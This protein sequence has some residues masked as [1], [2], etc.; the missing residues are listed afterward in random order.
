[1]IRRFF[2]ALL[3]ALMLTSGAY[4]AS[5]TGLV[6]LQ[7][8][9]E[10]DSAADQA[11]KLKI[12]DAC[13]DCAR[14]CVSGAPDA[15]AAYMRLQQHIGDFQ[16]ACEARARELGYA[17]TITAEAGVFAFPDRVYGRARVPAGDYPALRITI[18]AGEGRNWWCVLYP[19]LCSLDESARGI[20]DVIAWLRRRL[21]GD[22]DA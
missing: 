3:A 11:L 1:M 14:V 12:R 8:V 20:G 18:G 21:G 15:E 5:L 4:A 22:A 17:G 10:S 19:D 6:R 2:C 9:A 13:L 16:S 7:V